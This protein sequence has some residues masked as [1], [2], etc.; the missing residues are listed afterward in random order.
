MLTIKRKIVLAYTLAFGL[1][2]FSF[3][4]FLYEDTK[5]A[6]IGK[7]D[8][9]IESS[10]AKLST[11]LGEGDEETRTVE[12]QSGVVR[13][14]L[15]HLPG[16]HARLVRHD[17]TIVAEDSLLKMLPGADAHRIPHAGER[18]DAA[19]PDGQRYRCLRMPIEINDRDHPVME[20][21]VSLS[22][23]EETLRRLLLRLFIGIPLTLLITAL[24][25]Y[26]ITRL[27]FR[28][29]TGMVETAREITASNLH[30]RLSLPRAR[31][32]VRL[33]GETLNGMIE[34]IESAFRS[35][36]QFV[37]D[38]SHEIRTPLTV[39]CSEL[40]FAATQTTQA[41][42]KESIQTSLLEIDRLTKL[43]DGLL[44]LAKLDA[45]QL[46]LD[47]QPVRLDELLVECAQL[48]G[49]IA[50]KKNVQMKIDLQDPVEIRA[51]RETMK[52]AIVNLLDNAV[53]YSGENTVV[54]AAVSRHGA[55]G[56][57]VLLRFEDQGPGIPPTELPHIFTRFYRADPARS[58]QAGVGLG[59]AIVR[60]L[61]ELHGGTV[62]V[63]SELGKGTIFQIDLAASSP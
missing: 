53:K 46:K 7:L 14:E 28:P 56:E 35:Q 20:L 2:L 13:E 8:A 27:A 3:A 6:E 39:I 57:R 17:G 29:M 25:A 47:L 44:L 55:K 32:E 51:D 26:G 21:A 11:E 41:P 61:V 60:Q 31:D 54:T 4:S 34:R 48:I 24:A 59:L 40:E 18:F 5:E 58:E 9:R 52:R 38:A 15:S 62:T 42:V 50:R 1:M 16:V 19:S 10:A 12:G 36:K 63:A 30:R 43:T 45:S 49:T 33:L 23:V 22:E 37:A